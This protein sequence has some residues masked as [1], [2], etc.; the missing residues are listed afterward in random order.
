M[1]QGEVGIE[2]VFL[3]E[4][5]KGKPLDLTDVTEVKLVLRRGI[6]TFERNCTIL[7]ATAGKVKYVLTKD[8]LTKPGIYAFQLVIIYSDGGIVKTNI[9]REIV[10]DSLEVE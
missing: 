1:Q 10:Y 3:I 9:Y 5:E 6:T 7:D 2:W 4:D 8:D